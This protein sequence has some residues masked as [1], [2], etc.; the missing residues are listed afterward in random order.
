M[1][2]YMVNYIISGA[3]ENFN[4]ERQSSFLA[5]S[6]DELKEKIQ[7]IVDTFYKEFPAN[8]FP[9]AEI[10]V[11]NVFKEVPTPD[12]INTTRNITKGEA[13]VLSALAGLESL[14]G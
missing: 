1:E 11:V 7:G 9:K 12:G 6:Q 10:R 14:F 5:E 2:L 4:G 3:D 13:D 8:Q